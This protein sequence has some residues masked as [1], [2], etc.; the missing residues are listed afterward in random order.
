MEFFEAINRRYSVRGYKSDPVPDD[1]LEQVLEAGRRAPTACNKQPFRVV[2][3][4]TRER[5]EELARV[6]GR[7]WFSQAPIVLAV[8]AL[9]DE[10]W[11]SQA[12]KSYA[13]VD[14]AIVMDHMIL[15][16]TALGLGTCWVAAF[17]DA[18]AREVLGLPRG[19]EPIAFTPLGYAERAP[20]GTVRRPLADLVRYERW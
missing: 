2:V 19:V 5:E 1:V 6:Y 20:A 11:C 14:A 4:H 15:A 16:A 18:A 8:V 7:G 3:L 13:D 12:G 17:D 9:P 10:A